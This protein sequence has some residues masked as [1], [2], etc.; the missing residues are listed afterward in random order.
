MKQLLYSFFVGA[1]AL[2][3]ASAPAKAHTSRHLLTDN[4]A[5]TERKAAAT[6]TAVLKHTTRNKHSLTAKMR[7]SMRI[8]LGLEPRKVVTSPRQRAR[9]LH[10][11]QRQLRGQNRVAS[12]SR[13]RLCN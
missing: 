9:Q 13:W 8:L 10:A 6:K 11:N 2:A 3:L 4:P 12:R 1:T 7:H 5:A